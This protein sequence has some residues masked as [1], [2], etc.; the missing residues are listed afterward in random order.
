MA[1]YAGCKPTGNFNLEPL[2]FNTVAAVSNNEAFRFLSIKM[3]S[4][5]TGVEHCIPVM[6]CGH[7]CREHWHPLMLHNTV[8]YR[9]ST[10]VIVI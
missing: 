10:V 1:P 5:T 3:E 9:D 2:N 7:K 4:Q 8:S 6:C